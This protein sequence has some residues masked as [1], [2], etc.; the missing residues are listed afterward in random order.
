MRP[1]AYRSE[2]RDP[3]AVIV[4]H[5]SRQGGW[6]EAERIQLQEATFGQGIVWFCGSVL[7]RISAHEETM[8]CLLLGEYIFNLKLLKNSLFLKLETAWK[9]LKSSS[10][11]PSL[12]TPVCHL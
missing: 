4:P 2:R 6:R 8:Q 10:G 5:H 3:W 9:G 7:E 1:V 11:L 12:G